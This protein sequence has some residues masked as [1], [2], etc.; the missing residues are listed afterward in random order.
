MKVGF[1]GIGVM[2]R[3]MTLNLLKAEH[4]VT[5][6]ARHPDKPEVQ[7]VL[8][9]G[10][11]LAPSPRAV[12]MA[13]D[14][15]ITMVPNS[16]QVLEVVTG[17]QG[18]L[19]GA[20]KGLIIVDMSTIAPVVSRSLYE[21]AAEKGVQF[22]DAP[23]SGGSQGAVNGTLTIMVGGDKEAFDKALPVLEAMGKK[24]NI[25][26][27][28]TSGAGEIIKIVNN[29]LCGTIAAAT[30]EALVLGVKA[31]ADLE[32]MTRIIGVSTGGSW[33]LANQFP[34]RAFNG[35]FKPGFMTDLLH[36]DLGLALELAAE[37]QTSLPM[38]GLARQLYEMSRASGH[39]SDDYTALMHVLEQMAGVEVRSKES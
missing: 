18:V 24:E 19:E 29:L 8:Q 17:P 22:L 1:I 21:Q 37:Y 9:A 27:V 33:Q 3:P 35:S 28:G 11:K 16:P 15:V 39:G 20:R 4:E 2:G 25:V 30:S 5:I 34:L 10:A 7:E 32:T 12:A 23:V 36:K 38:T 26:Y 6:F 13:S 31:G 14:I